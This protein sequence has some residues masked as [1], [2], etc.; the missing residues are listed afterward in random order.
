MMNNPMF[1]LMQ[2]M[3]SGKNPGFLLQQ[4]A[5]GDPRVRQIMDMTR[6]KNPQ[7]LRQMAENMAKERGMNIDDIARQLGITIPSNR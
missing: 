6:G 1:S 5:Q 4:M 3:Q 2:A 7:Q